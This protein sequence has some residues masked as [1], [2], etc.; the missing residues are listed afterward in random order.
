M[1]AKSLNAAL[2]SQR[3]RNGM[4]AAQK[5]SWALQQANPHPT[6]PLGFQFPWIAFQRGEDGSPKR[7]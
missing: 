2:L 6:S 4:P 1:N 7:A 3:A 5:S